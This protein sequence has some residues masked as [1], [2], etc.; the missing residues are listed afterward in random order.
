MGWEL[1]GSKQYFYSSA[2][3]DGEPRKIYHGSGSSGRV[4][5]ILDRQAA[6]RRVADWKEGPALR[7]M[8]RESDKLWTEV[9]SWLRLLA[10]SEML[11]A[12]WYRHRGEWRQARRSARTRQKHV[13]GLQSQPSGT[14]KE[15]LK[16]LNA[17]ADAG[18]EGGL[19]EL[20]AFFVG[21]S[22]IWSTMANLNVTLLAHWAQSGVAG[23]TIESITRHVQR[24]RVEMVT[25]EYKPIERALADAVIVAELILATIE[26]HAGGPLSPK[27]EIY[28]T[29]QLERADNRVRATRQTLVRVQ[30]ALKRQ[31][32]LI[33][34]AIRHPIVTHDYKV[35]TG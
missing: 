19:G 32:G 12:G 11:L 6:R 16:S 26:A 20:R 5:E 25:S 33:V 27:A 1:R 24:R 22:S 31:Q 9:W 28:L 3:I 8:V 34:P 14:L 2:R 23:G 35:N 21:N 30:S 15:Q 4:H 29:K 7:R 17:R 18:E 10:D 13:E